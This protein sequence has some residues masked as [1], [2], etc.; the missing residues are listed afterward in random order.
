[1]FYLNLTLEDKRYKSINK[2][3]LF[4]YEYIR[5]VFVVIN[6]SNWV[7]KSPLDYDED[8]Y[9]IYFRNNDRTDQNPFC[10]YEAL[11]IT[12]TTKN[13]L[14]NSIKAILPCFSLENFSKRK[15][16]GMQRN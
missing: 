9:E 13:D 1:M 6:N 5:H 7:Y 10:G 8:T 16:F 11:N 12:Q 4:V 2:F 14:I 15:L 3:L